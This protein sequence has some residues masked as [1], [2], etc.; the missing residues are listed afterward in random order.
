MQ[1]LSGGQT[2]F[3]CHQKTKCVIASVIIDIC[4]K[5]RNAPGSAQAADISAAIREISALYRP[6]LEEYYERALKL[7]TDRK[8]LQTLHD[9]ATAFSFHQRFAETG[10]MK[11]Q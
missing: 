5:T 6:L 8:M 2:H 3:C 4:R 10:S 7:A 9:L 11:K 1:V